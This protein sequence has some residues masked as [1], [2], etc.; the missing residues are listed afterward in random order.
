[1][2]QAITKTVKTGIATSIANRGLNA[3]YPWLNSPEDFNF[4]PVVNIAHKIYELTGLTLSSYILESE[5]VINWRHTLIFPFNSAFPY[6]LN[7]NTLC[8]TLRTAVA[9]EFGEVYVVLKGVGMNIRL[10]IT[11]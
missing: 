7:M 4:E 6:E 8:T 10:I 3:K 11:V 9:S 1:M 2:K 5:N